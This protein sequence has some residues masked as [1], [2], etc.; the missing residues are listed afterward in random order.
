MSLIFAYTKRHY[1]AGCGKKDL[2]M[3]PHVFVWGQQVVWLCRIRN[4]IGIMGSQTIFT[5]THRG[6][7]DQTDT[8]R[9]SSILWK[10]SRASKS[11]RRRISDNSTH[12]SSRR[13]SDK[14]SLKRFLVLKTITTYIRSLGKAHRYHEHDIS[15]DPQADL[16]WWVST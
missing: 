13:L 4:C 2:G 12:S 9:K 14:V 11:F 5:H 1:F 3:W 7:D 16:M 6:W 10:L 8:Q 15:A